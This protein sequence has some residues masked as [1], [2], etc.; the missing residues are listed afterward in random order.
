MS[1]NLNDQPL[2]DRGFDIWCKRPANPQTGEPAGE[3][4]NEVTEALIWATMIVGADG[5]KINTFAQRVREYEIVCGPLLD[6]PLNLH[7]AIECNNIRPDTFTDDGYISKAELLRH[8][9][10]RMNAS[11]LTDAQW[12]KKLATLVKEKATRSLKREK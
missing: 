1:L 7:L 12:A 3:Y 5:R 10:M 8:E 4:L 6:K 9:G 2:T 11:S